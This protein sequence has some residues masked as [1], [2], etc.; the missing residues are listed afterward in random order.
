MKLEHL[1][2]L[3]TCYNKSEFIQRIAPTLLEIAD[4]GAEVIIIDDCSTDDSY[5]KLVEISKQSSNILLVSHNR[6][7]G[8]AN[9]RN[10][11][12]EQASRDFLFFLDIDDFLSIPV[13]IEMYQHASRNRLDLVRASYSNSTHPNHPVGPSKHLSG[14][15]SIREV[16]SVIAHE[17]GYWRYLYSSNF[18]KMMKVHFLPTREQLEDKHF[19]LDDLFWMLAIAALD[20]SIEILAS[21][22]I[23]YVYH[24]TIHNVSSWKQFQSQAELVPKAALLCLKNY[25]NNANIDIGIF[26]NLILDV[27][28]KHL[29]YVSFRAFIR[30]ANCYLALS[31]NCGLPVLK[32][33]LNFLQLANRTSRNSIHSALSRA[34]S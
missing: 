33:A 12:L 24:E 7:L 5:L 19:I 18:I 1:S 27:S 13:L 16:R 23:V 34:R 31:R 32:I 15:F 4:L 9:T 20:G 8:S 11:A 14:L 6:N 26:Q 2:V 17:L 25:R 30:Q 21:Q 10:H 29:R 22:K 3:V 28:F